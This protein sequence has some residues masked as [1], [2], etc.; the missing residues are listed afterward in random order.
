MVLFLYKWIP[1]RLAQTKWK[2]GQPVAQDLGPRGCHGAWAVA[3][4]HGCRTPHTHTADTGMCPH[5]EGSGAGSYRSLSCPAHMPVAIRV[6]VD[7]LPYF[8]RID[9]C[10]YCPPRREEKC[11][12]T[13][14]SKMR[15]RGL[16]STFYAPFPRP[17]IRQQKCRAEKQVPQSSFHPPSMH[18][19]ETISWQ[20]VG[21]I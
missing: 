18:Y 17:H 20:R 4:L 13:K 15:V 8:K 3:V 6:C 21:F 10:H 11:C 7:H 5:Q 9:R 19:S 12:M 16:G 2:S 1:F 14:G